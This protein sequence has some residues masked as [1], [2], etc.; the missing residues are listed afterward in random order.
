MC[1]GRKLVSNIKYY[2]KS[3]YY[4]PSQ[5]YFMKLNYIYSLLFHIL[6]TMMYEVGYLKDD[7][8]FHLRIPNIISDI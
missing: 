6:R 5:K 7:N 8:I 3:R 4:L 2:L 1:F